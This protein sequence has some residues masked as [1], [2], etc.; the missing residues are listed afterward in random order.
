MRL[1]ER[2]VV[3]VPRAEDPDRYTRASPLQRVHPDAPP[4]LVVQGTSDNLVFPVESQAFVERLRTISRSPVAYIEVPRAHHEFDALP[5]VRT[6][7]VV[8]GVER[9]LTH[10]RAAHGGSASSTPS[11]TAFT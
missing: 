5:S 9:F 4:F 6:G 7:H 3:K 10:V 1:V 8:T 11:A 2:L